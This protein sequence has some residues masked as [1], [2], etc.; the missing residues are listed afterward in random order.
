MPKASGSVVPSDRDV[1]LF[2]FGTGSC[3]FIFFGVVGGTDECGLGRTGAGFRGSFGGG[4]LGGNLLIKGGA[5]IVLRDVIIKGPKPLAGL[6]A[7][8]ERPAATGPESG[9]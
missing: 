2:E 5:S 1:V 6:V 4:G 7:T 8:W 9:C 3:L